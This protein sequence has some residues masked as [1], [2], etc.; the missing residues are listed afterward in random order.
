VHLLGNDT[1][2]AQLSTQI[3]SHIGFSGNSSNDGLQM[4]LLFCLIRKL[5]S[6]SQVKQSLFYE[7]S[8][9]SLLLQVLHL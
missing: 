9:L 8:I 6:S 1:H 5:I 4:Q 7:E 3:N 2:L